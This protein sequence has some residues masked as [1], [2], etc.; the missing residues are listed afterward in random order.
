MGK[1]GVYGKGEVEVLSAMAT[2]LGDIS[3]G[4]EASE[5][6]IY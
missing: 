6:L 4:S 3:G 5:L 1:E 2:P